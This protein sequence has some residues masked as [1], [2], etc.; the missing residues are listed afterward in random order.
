MPRARQSFFR[1]CAPA[2]LRFNGRSG[3]A[4]GRQIQTDHL[5]YT[6]PS[7]RCCNILLENHGPATFSTHLLAHLLPAR[8]VPLQVPVRKLHSCLFRPFR[9]KLQRHLARSSQVRAERP[10]RLQMPGQHY[11]LR[12]LPGHHTPPNTLL[13]ICVYFV[14]PATRSRIHQDVLKRCSADVVRRRPPR[15]HLFREHPKCAFNGDVYVEGPSY[16][17]RCCG[18]RRH[19]VSPSCIRLPQLSGRLRELYPKGRRNDRARAPGLPDSIGKCDAC[20][21]GGREPSAP[22]SGRAS[23]AKPPV[24]KLAS[25]RPI[26]SPPPGARQAS[27]RWPAGWDRRE[28]STRSVCKYPLTVSYSL[29]MRRVKRY[30][31]GLLSRAFRTLTGRCFRNSLRLAWLHS[32]PLRPERSAVALRGL[33]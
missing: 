6:F 12:R 32:A 3:C 30:F 19:F 17:C 7:L 31:S 29:L 15:P 26:H 8:P 4:E 13:A 25:P 10:I 33:P 21:R 14:P 27:R 1:T 24:V 11:F 20:R 16:G 5:H 22:L 18:L 28:H 9:H 23:A 2:R